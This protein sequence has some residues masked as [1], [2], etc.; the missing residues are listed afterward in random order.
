MDRLHVPVVRW[1]TI[2]S[3]ATWHNQL[4]P[5]RAS[6]TVTGYTLTQSKHHTL[7]A[8]Y[9][10]GGTDHTRSATSEHWQTVNDNAHA[11]PA[12]FDGGSYPN[13]S[14]SRP[15]IASTASINSL[16]YRHSG[17]CSKGTTTSAA[18]SSDLLDGKMLCAQVLGARFMT[19][20]DCCA[21]QFALYGSSSA[22]APR[23]KE[24]HVIKLA[25]NIDSNHPGS[26]T[27]TTTTITTTHSITHP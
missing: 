14:I 12:H 13:S 1:W 19:V 11:A 3:N 26:T 9:R 22:A 24:H 10:Q 21:K 17:Y 20:T 7:N 16:S 27:T 8:L 23:H 6:G 4:T 18:Q 2:R 25:C 15:A 5:H